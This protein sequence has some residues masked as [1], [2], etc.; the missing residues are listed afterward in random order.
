M[1]LLLLLL[2]AMMMVMVMM[3]DENGA[4]TTEEHDGQRW[5]QAQQHTAHITRYIFRLPKG[6]YIMDH[7]H[8]I[9]I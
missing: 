8:I 6:T 7:G 1:I 3:M 9:I 2:S 5:R 4:T